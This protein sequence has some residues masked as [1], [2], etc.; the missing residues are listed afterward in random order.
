MQKDKTKIIKPGNLTIK[1]VPELIFYDNK[2]TY[3]ALDR[4]SM[5]ASWHNTHVRPE[6]Q[7]NKLKISKNRGSSWKTVTFR[8]GIYDN[9]GINQYIH[10]KIGK[11]SGKDSYG[12]YL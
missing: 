5:N 10:T 8:S 12:Y 6:Y 7:N 1:M 4:L 11:L 9:E 2:P 3:L